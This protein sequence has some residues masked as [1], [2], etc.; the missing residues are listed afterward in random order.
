[1]N[2]IPEALVNSFRAALLD[3]QK[4]T[5]STMVKELSENGTDLQVIYE[6]LL[7]PSLYYIGELWEYNKI[8]VATEHL[9]SSIVENILTE[10]Y[11]YLKPGK[12]TGKTTLLCCVPGEYHQIGIKMVNDTLE[13]NGWETYFLGA[14]VPVKDLVSFASGIK[15][16]LFT[17]SLSLYFNLPALEKMIEQ[18]RIQFPETIILAG[19]QGFRK[20]GKDSIKN[21]YNVVVENNLYELDKFLKNNL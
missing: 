21:K 3:G 5:C 13:Q 12:P 20:A 2:D 11:T 19:G 18:I 9:A 1:M 7:K 4:K 16:E 17:I 6:Q 14:N 15:P 10:L 8:T